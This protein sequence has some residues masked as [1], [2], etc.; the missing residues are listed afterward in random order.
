MLDVSEWVRQQLGVNLPMHQ[1]CRE[2]CQGIC[3]EC[4]KNLNLGPCSCAPQPADPRWSALGDILG[5]PKE[6]RE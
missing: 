2:D 1:L 5:Q 4:G 3:T 6:N